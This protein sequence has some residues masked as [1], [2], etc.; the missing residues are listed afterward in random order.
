MLTAIAD[1]GTADGGSDGAPADDV[2]LD[3]VAIG[4]ATAGADTPA[5]SPAA[6]SSTCSF[7]PDGSGAADAPTVPPS[8]PTKAERGAVVATSAGRIPITLDPT[9]APCTVT[10]FIALAKQGFF[11]GTDCHRLTTDGIYVLQCGD[12][13]GTGTGG[14]GYSFADELDGAE[15]YGP[16]TLAMANAGPN[17]NGSQF[18]MVYGDSPLPASYNVFGSISPA[19]LK[20]LKKVGRAGVQGGGA[21]GAPKTP[22]TITK[23]S[24]D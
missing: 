11:D 20:V 19:G 23:V 18:F 2:T 9:T 22:V 15:T 24:L 3:F 16:G 14:P 1:K 17:T 7:L 8:K 6:A 5:T 4:A 10:S 21:D 13:T 12:P